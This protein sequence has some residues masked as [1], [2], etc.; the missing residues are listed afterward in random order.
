M[1]MKVTPPEAN[2]INAIDVIEHILGRDGLIEQN[3]DILL[4]PIL[5]NEITLDVLFQYREWFFA[6]VPT[7]EYLLTLKNPRNFYLFPDKQSIVFNSTFDRSWLDCL[8]KT[9]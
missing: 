9:F 2:V 8:E 7:Y 6:F 4:K 1:A 3:K 5:F